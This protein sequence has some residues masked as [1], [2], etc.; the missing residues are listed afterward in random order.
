MLVVKRPISEKPMAGNVQKQKTEL[1]ISR[2]Y[3]F[4]ITPCAYE[5]QYNHKSE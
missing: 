1:N 4:Q 2:K 5:D 3:T